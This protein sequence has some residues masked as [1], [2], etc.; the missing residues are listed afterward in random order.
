M[1]RH[2]Q[3]LGSHIEAGIDQGCLRLLIEAADGLDGGGCQACRG[4]LHAAR[5]ETQQAIA[6]GLD[7]AFAMELFSL[8]LNVKE[9]L[10]TL[11]PEALRAAIQ[12]NLVDPE[13]TRLATD[14]FG[15]RLSYRDKYRGELKI[16]NIA[17]VRKGGHRVEPSNIVLGNVTQ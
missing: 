12:H 7:K 15:D 14:P 9:A 5:I 16:N 1:D 11:D 8:E 3:R 17:E 6:K 10:A 4:G 13:K 2:V